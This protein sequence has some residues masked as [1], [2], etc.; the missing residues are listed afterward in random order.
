M[1]GS[2]DLVQRIKD[3]V[4]LIQVGDLVSAASKWA[5]MTGSTYKDAYQEV[6]AVEPWKTQRKIDKERKVAQDG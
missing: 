2:F 1:N 3:V 4:A 6:A 5:A